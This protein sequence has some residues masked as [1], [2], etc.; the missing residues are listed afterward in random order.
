MFF[1]I[2][3]VYSGAV[4][5]VVS[6]FTTWALLSTISGQYPV[7]TG[8]GKN[9]MGEMALPSAEG[10]SERSC[11]NQAANT[12]QSCRRTWG[13]GASGLMWLTR[14]SFVVK[15]IKQRGQEYEWL[16]QPHCPSVWSS[17]PPC[18]THSSVFTLLLLCASPQGFTQGSGSYL[19]LIMET[20]PVLC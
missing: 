11:Q 19:C 1:Y 17:H 18:M 20:S 4:A 15:K 3:L 13:P 12:H 10:C 16:S 6:A 7:F 2:T 9:R 5:R 14:C 8:T